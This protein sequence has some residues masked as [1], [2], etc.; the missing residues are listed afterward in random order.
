MHLLGNHG[1]VPWEG[2]WFLPYKLHMGALLRPRRGPYLVCS[3]I[4]M[5]DQWVSVSA[6]LLLSRSVVSDS[7]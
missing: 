2:Q 3:Y 1:G 4:F 6:L 7:L 5:A